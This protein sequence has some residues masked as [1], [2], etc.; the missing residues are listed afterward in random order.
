MER[1]KAHP[2]KFLPGAHTR[3][4]SPPLSS[5][6]PRLTPLWRGSRAWKSGASRVTHDGCPRADSTADTRRRAVARPDA[7]THAKLAKVGEQIAHQFS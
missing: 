1:V 2:G 6:S 7:A 5:S 3:G 4:G